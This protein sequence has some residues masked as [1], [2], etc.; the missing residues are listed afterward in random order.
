[1]TKA[2]YY[3]PPKD[4]LRRE[5]YQEALKRI[6]G[7]RHIRHETAVELAGGIADMAAAKA[8]AAIDEAKALRTEL[9]AYKRDMHNATVVSR[10]L[11]RSLERLNGKETNRPQQ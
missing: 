8:Y 1:M 2:N 6:K 10:S 3:L 5:I 9:A 7:T 11:A 4:T